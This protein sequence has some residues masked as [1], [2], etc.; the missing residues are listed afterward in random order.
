ME[1]LAR[2]LE[3][4]SGR[5][6]PELPTVTGWISERQC[7]ND[8][9]QQQPVVVL[10]SPNPQVALG[11]S[12]RGLLT[13]G[14]ALLCITACTRRPQ[15]MKTT[16]HFALGR[17]Q[18]LLLQ[19]EVEVGGER[20]PFLFDTGAGMTCLTPATAE[21]LGC[22][23]AGRVTGFRK[24]GERINGPKCEA[25]PLLLDGKVQV[26]ADCMVLDLMKLLPPDWPPLSGAIALNS[27]AGRALGLYRARQARVG[28]TP[29]A[30]MDGTGWREGRAR[31]A[32]EVGGASLTMFVA[33]ETPQ[34]TLWFL[35]DTG[36]TG[37]TLIAPHAAALLGI[38]D[39]GQP[40]QVTVKATG[41]GT[42]PLDAV[43]QEMIHDGL[44]GLPAMEDWDLVMDLAT[45]RYWLRS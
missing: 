3:S 1:L 26:E 15:D 2:G 19:T 42:L 36:N 13:T 5:M 38:T 10:K 14:A 4:A 41:V 43:I 25:V 17:Y 11:M 9:L 7:G 30:V 35:L 27:V 37:P 18:D 6:H 39:K 44:I 33:I 21:I 20:L 45:P 8:V 12:R 28:A 40:Q 22:S 31:I 24:S 34:T 29:D 32:R 23:P 16:A